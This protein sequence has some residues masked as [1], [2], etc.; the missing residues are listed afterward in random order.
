MSVL[1]T[2]STVTVGFARGRSASTIT[3]HFG[4]AWRVDIVKSTSS[5][6]DRP[7]AR[8]YPPMDQNT[9]D[10]VPVLEGMAGR[11]GVRQ[12]TLVECRG[13]ADGLLTPVGAARPR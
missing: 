13:A 11:G 6:Q 8:H 2:P 9:D 12:G 5:G 10:P 4:R 3:T 7:H 1:N